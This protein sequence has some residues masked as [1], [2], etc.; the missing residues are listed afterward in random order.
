[1][2]ES[3]SIKEDTQTVRVYA[4]DNTRLLKL[5]DKYGLRSNAGMIRKLLDIHDEMEK[6]V[7]S[8]DGN[9]ISLNMSYYTSC[10]CVKRLPL[11][12]L[13]FPGDVCVFPPTMYNVPLTK[14]VWKRLQQEFF[15]NSAPESFQEEELY[16]FFH[17]LNLYYDKKISRFFVHER[18]QMY[19]REEKYT[20]EEDGCPYWLLKVERGD[21]VDNYN[22][23][24]S[25]FSRYADPDNLV[26]IATVLADDI[27]EDYE[28]LNIFFPLRR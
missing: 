24:D 5:V 15:D 18:L 20:Y 13:T 23:L 10:P 8:K 22:D 19:L 14:S 2:R 3:S 11:K 12:K 26:R 25:K 7:A 28:Q 1:M 9:E 16:S 17:V 21:F 4:K 27:G 6:N